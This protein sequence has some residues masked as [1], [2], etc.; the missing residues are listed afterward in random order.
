MP[1][2]MP[3]A[4][5]A[6]ALFLVFS[7][8]G[9]KKK[10]AAAADCADPGMP[11]EFENALNTL[12]ADDTIPAGNLVAAALDELNVIHIRHAIRSRLGSRLGWK[13]L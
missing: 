1:A 3:L 2:L 5:G 11:V 13:R 4:I 7:K 10:K 9:D 12:L 6:A 8:T